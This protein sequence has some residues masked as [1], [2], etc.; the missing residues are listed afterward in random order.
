MPREVRDV[1]QYCYQRVAGPDLLTVSVE[2]GVA[3]GDT[4]EQYPSG[5]SLRAA[6]SN[7]RARTPAF[8]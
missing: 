3:H 1:P 6:C 8:L 2:D 5:C 7:S 4:L